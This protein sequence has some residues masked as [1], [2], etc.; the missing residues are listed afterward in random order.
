[1]VGNIDSELQRRKRLG[2]AE[3]ARMLPR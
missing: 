1:M 3:A 2:I